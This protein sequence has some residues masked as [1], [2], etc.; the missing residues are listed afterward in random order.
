M[1]T[2]I[3]GGP[4]TSRAVLT[5][6]LWVLAAAVAFAATGGFAI[7][8]A[9]PRARQAISID[10]TAKRFTFVPDR[11]EVVEGDLVTLSVASADGTHGIA[12]KKLKLKKEI[13]RGGSAVMLSFIAPEPGSYAITC[14]EYCG[15]GHDTMTATLVV[16]PRAVEERIYPR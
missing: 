3:L 16:V 10:L 14:S 15:R 11:L 12:I 8:K 7:T 2:S 4:V 9:E 13:P 1:A 5:R 6:V